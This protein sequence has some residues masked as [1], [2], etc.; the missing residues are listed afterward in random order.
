MR[1]LII[2]A[3]LGGL[4]LL[5][6]LRRAGIDA[7][8][9]ERSAD[10]GSQPASYGI[11]LDADGLHALHDSLPAENW[12]RIDAAGVPA[13]LI[14]RF[15]DPHRG[16]LAT[17][18]KRFPEHATNPITKRRAISRGKLRDALLHGTDED[19]D[20]EP[21]VHWG[22]T[23]TRYQMHDSGVRAFFDD[24]THADGDLLIGADG[25]NS[26]VRHQ[27]LP[28][29]QRQDLGIVNIAGRVPLS[30][31][32]A[33][34]LPAELVDGGINNVVPARTGWMFL[35]TWASGDPD[36]T[37]YV[38]W[39][40]AAAETSYPH[41]VGDLDGAR[42][43]NLVTERIKG[44]TA[45]LRTLV[46]ATDPSTITTVPLRTMP[47][48]PGWT[49]SRVTLLGD[50]IH[51]MTPM[52]GIGANTALRDA[53]ELRRSLIAPADPIDSIATYET[54]MRDYANRALKLSTRNA[55]NAAL[56]TPA[57]R[58]AFRALLRIGSH[59]APLQRRMFGPTV[60]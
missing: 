53:D 6:G 43:K 21:L 23:F 4:T 20:S 39:A 54:A 48:L 58:A 31:A 45:P 12:K 13:P 19:A 46:D 27:R 36:T 26:R 30:G 55:T 22:K 28:D 56:A 47:Q 29:L 51:N 59:F 3:G 10:S 37:Q 1:V 24:G 2:G 15:H 40:W 32:V 33:A 9:Y 5:H 49:P 38:V 34:A 16:V 8:V 35:S 42:L 41:G 50:A 60:R 57:N 17:I 18:D 7:R 25:S 44:W 11:H 52:A 14:I